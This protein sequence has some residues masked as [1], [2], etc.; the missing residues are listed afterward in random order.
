M[1]MECHNVYRHDSLLMIYVLWACVREW[2]L[3]CIVLLSPVP[4][5]FPSLQ[6]S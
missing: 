3:R 5:P 6:V 2:L 1:V 4:V